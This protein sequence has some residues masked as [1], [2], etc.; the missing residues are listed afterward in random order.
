MAECFSGSAG[1]TTCRQKL[2]EEDNH[3]HEGERGQDSLPIEGSVANLSKQ[4]EYFCNGGESIPGAQLADIPSRGFTKVSSPLIKGAQLKETRSCSAV[5]GAPAAAP[6]VPEVQPLDRSI[7]DDKHEGDGGAVEILLHGLSR[8]FLVAAAAGGKSLGV[9]FV[10]HATTSDNSGKT[11]TTAA[12]VSSQLRT[13]DETERG[14]SQHRPPASPSTNRSDVGRMGRLRFLRWGAEQPVTL[15]EDLRNPVALCVSSSDSSVFVLEEV[16]ERKRCEDDDDH[17]DR[18]RD[19]PQQHPP[20]TKERYRV[21]RLDG[22]R[23]CAW[24]TN[25]AARRSAVSG[26]DFATPHKRNGQADNGSIELNAGG[27]CRP[28]GC[29]ADDTILLDDESETEW[30]TSSNSDGGDF[31]K[32]RHRGVSRS[33][34]GARLNENRPG[35]AVHTRGRRRAVSFAQVLEM[36]SA[37]ARAK[38]KESHHPEKPVDMCVLTDGT[39]IVAFSRSAPL[40]GGTS[41]AESQGVLRAFPAADSARRKGL[42][43]VGTAL[44]SVGRV[45]DEYAGHD[46]DDS[47]LVAEG[48]PVITGLAAGAGDAVYL[49]LCGARHDGAVTAIGALSTRQ[50]RSLVR[51][52]GPRKDLRSRTHSPKGHGELP[53]GRGNKLATGGGKYSGGVHRSDEGFVRIASGFA[54]ALAVDEDTNL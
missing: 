25:E 52:G 15:V 16:L 34:V 54:T 9:F 31:D 33:S 24:F 50:R 13:L 51:N 44:S 30:E 47:W 45:A 19:R 35:S 21:C 46:V 4:K 43:N 10:D 6:S 12:A 17:R 11:T 1:G 26:S 37:S 27:E 23:L 2:S 14:E 3:Y 53:T 20:R 18:D 48:L 7:G 8:P 29:A 32:R 38:R 22:A 49:S 5:Y 28:L 42:G 41:I 39:I 40:H 36:P